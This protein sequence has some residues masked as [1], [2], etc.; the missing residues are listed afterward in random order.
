MNEE[1]LYKILNEPINSLVNQYTE[2]FKFDNVKL[3]FK[4]D[5]LKAIVRLAIERRTGARA[6][7]SILE[8]IM[9]EIM[10]DIPNHK[11][12]ESCIITKSVITKKSKPEITFYKKTA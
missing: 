12:I 5:A 9:M 3:F 2:L 10:Y 11:N 1:A 7:R 8:E 4:K 6:L